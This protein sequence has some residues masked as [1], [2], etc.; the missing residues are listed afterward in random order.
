MANHARGDLIPTEGY[1]SVYGL[2]LSLDVARYVSTALKR[3]KPDGSFSGGTT[4]R[5]D[6]VMFAIL[7][8]LLLSMGE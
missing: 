3:Q 5:Y 6:A 1:A 2:N 8:D 7:S 4:T